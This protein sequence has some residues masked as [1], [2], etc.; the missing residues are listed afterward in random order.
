MEFLP[1]IA[2]SSAGNPGGGAKPHGPLDVLPP[3]AP[4][5]TTNVTETD[6]V[7]N[8]QVSIGTVAVGP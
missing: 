2:S 4:D 5:D 6:E 3:G 7:N 1:G 8:C